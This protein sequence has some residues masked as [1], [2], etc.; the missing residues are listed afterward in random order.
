MTRSETHT[1]HL[2]LII[3]I[4]CFRH[5]AIQL[6]VQLID[7]LRRSETLQ[8]L[9]L[10]ELSLNRSI[11]S[12]LH[13][14]I[15]RQFAEVVEQYLLKLSTAERIRS[16]AVLAKR[17]RL[18]LYDNFR[19]PQIDGRVD[20]VGAFQSGETLVTAEGG[21]SEEQY[22]SQP[23]SWSC[24][25]LRMLLLSKYDS[26]SNHY[27]VLLSSAD[28]LLPSSTLAN[29]CRSLCTDIHDSRLS[30]SNQG[31]SCRALLVLVEW[32]DKFSQS[33]AS[34][35]SSM[36]KFG[37]SQSSGSLPMTAA[38]QLDTKETVD[39]LRCALGM[40]SSKLNQIRRDF[41]QVRACKCPLDETVCV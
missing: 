25:E 3:I 39:I 31:V 11:C 22:M 15:L 19:K 18:K 9:L 41:S 29:L 14:A 12:E 8:N 30:V 28:R 32:I 38:R 24:S 36:S 26:C 35:R 13:S 40:A 21:A 37:L 27:R 7:Q 4:V 16:F 17:N 1:H 20:D 23:H 5:Y 10:S 2:S 33:G 6:R 34:T